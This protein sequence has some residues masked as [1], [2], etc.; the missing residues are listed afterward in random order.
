MEKN[1]SYKILNSIVLLGLCFTVLMLI[2]TPLIT[3]AFLKSR[4]FVIDNGLVIK[5]SILIY[6]CAI[7]YVMALLNL[8]KICKLLVKDNPFA[9]KISNYLR[10]I[11]FCSFSEIIVV[12]A[13][14]IYLKSSISLFENALIVGPILIVTF[15]A[16]TIGF[17]FLVLSQLFNIF[18]KIKEE[19]DNTI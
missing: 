18:I 15:I 2:A 10:K 14:L 16:A 11:A 12:I 7:P 19:N 17:L 5:I 13:S 8:K 1:T 9:T 4:Y 6:I 3:T